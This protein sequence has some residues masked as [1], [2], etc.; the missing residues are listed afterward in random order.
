MFCWCSGLHV[1]LKKCRY[2]VVPINFEPFASFRPS[3]AL[4]VYPFV[5]PLQKERT[6]ISLQSDLLRASGPERKP[7]KLQRKMN[8]LN[9]NSVL[10]EVFV[11]VRPFFLKFDWLRPVLL[12]FNLTFNTWHLKFN[13]KNGKRPHIE[14]CILLGG[15][16]YI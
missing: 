2:V 1:C 16:W 3:A 10:R 8:F 4:L 14:S 12:H 11:P 6:A 5:Y 9:H 7:G 15:W 13:G